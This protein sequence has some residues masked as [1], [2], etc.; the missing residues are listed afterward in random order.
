VDVA[1]IETGL[2]GRLDAT[3][4]VQP[5]VSV[6]TRIDFDHMEYLGTTL[7][8][9]AGEKAGIIKEG[10]PAIV[11]PQHAD[12]RDVFLRRA[13]HVGTACTFAEDVV[14]CELDTIHPDLTM[15]VS[16]TR[17]DDRR[18]FTTD[19]CGE[20]PTANITTALAAI[21]AIRTVYFIEEDHIRDGLATVKANSGLIGRCDVLSRD[22]LTIIDVAHNPGGLEALCRTLRSAGHA[23]HSFQ[24]VFG[25]MADKDVGGMLDAIAPMAATVHACAPSLPRALPVEDLLTLAF[26]RGLTATVAHSSVR[27]ALA[28]A[29]A[30]G[31]TLVCGSFHVL[32]EALAP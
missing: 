28:A 24:V 6:I 22:P 19:L 15:T 32:D 29:R 27:H 10:A 23:E 18:Y 26:G 21:P 3:N 11:G 12:L 30:A 25:A 14:L 17:D 4:V 1:V 5:F 20:H 9:I 16:V 7:P 13:A 2:G 31:P 8:L